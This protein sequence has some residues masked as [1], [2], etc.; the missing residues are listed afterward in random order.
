MR[1]IWILP[2]I[3]G[4]AV[5]IPANYLI[6]NVTLLK[7]Y[8]GKPATDVWMFEIELLALKHFKAY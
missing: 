6:H 5:T 4:E 2:E 3:T 1:S 8:Y 7:D